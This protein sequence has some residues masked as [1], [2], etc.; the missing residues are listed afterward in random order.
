MTKYY[1]R[2]S[3]QKYHSL[4]SVYKGELVACKFSADLNYYRARVVAFKDNTVDL[5]FVDFGGIEEKSI[6]DV[7]EIKKDFLELKFQ[8]IQC[9]MAHIW[10]VS[11]SEWSGE[12][13]EVFESLTHCAMWARV[14]ECTPRDGGKF[15]PCVEL[16]GTNMAGGDMN[17]GVEL[18]REGDDRRVGESQTPRI[19][20]PQNK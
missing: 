16:I 14:V 6:G 8:A 3:H 5:D 13:C 9:S 11:E 1:S 19:D 15:I 12:A 10:P 20:G 2:E 18:V 17:V 4:I 7:F